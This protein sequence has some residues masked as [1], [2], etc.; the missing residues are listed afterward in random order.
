MEKKTSTDISLE[1]TYRWPT[2]IQKHC[3]LLEKC[4]KTTTRSHLTPIKW[5]SLKSLQLNGRGKVW[6]KGNLPTLLVE[7]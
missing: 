7:M 3:L 4:I 2:G 6:K 5:L 1:K